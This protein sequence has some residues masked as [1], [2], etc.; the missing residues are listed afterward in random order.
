[1]RL[2]EGIRAMPIAMFLPLSLLL[3]SLGCAPGPTDTPEAETVLID[4]EVEDSAV[5]STT[6][7]EESGAETV[8]RLDDFGKTAF[9]ALEEP[10]D[11]TLVE[12][13]GYRISLDRDTNQITF[14]GTGFSE[15]FDLDARL[16]DLFPIHGEG[17]CTEDPS[18]VWP[19]G[20]GYYLPLS[21]MTVTFEIAGGTLTMWMLLLQGEWNVDSETFTFGRL[22]AI[23]L[24]DLE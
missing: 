24:V 21:D 5:L 10:W 20:D 17:W 18:G 16:A 11:T 3:A 1:M 23:V 7:V 22:N 6:G 14:S 2:Q 19:C 8:I 13:D 4:Y 9:G 15:V 12:Q